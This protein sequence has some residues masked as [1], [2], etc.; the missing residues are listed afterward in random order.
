MEDV[1]KGFTILSFGLILF[2]IVYEWLMGRNKDGK[3]TKQDWQ[4]FGISV[5]WLTIIERPLLIFCS[6]GLCFLLFPQQRGGLAWLEEENLLLTIIAFVLID[7]FLH[8]A[9]HYF[10]HARRVKNKWL[11]KVQNYYKVT[12]RT[13]HLHGGADNN[14]Q[15]G[16]TQTITVGWGWALA[17]PNYWFGYICLYFGLLETW[18]IGTAMKSLWGIHNHANL[19]YDLKLLAHKNKWVRKLMYG[20]CHIFVFPN[21]HHHHHS[22]SQNSARNLQNFIA[23]YDWLLWNKLTIS[24]E[25]PKIYGWRKNEKEEGSVLYRYFY[26]SLARRA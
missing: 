18:A 23:I 14:G 16:V 3:K 17:L 11:E 6:F 26:R 12:H 7:E 1:D 20:L 22:R 15:L 21:Q 2:Y 4:M 10:S 5:A 19:T 8:G 25:R 24:S 9:V 13:H